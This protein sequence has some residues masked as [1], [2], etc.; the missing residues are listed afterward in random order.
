MHNTKKEL[1][2]FGEYIISVKAFIQNVGI[3][4]INLVILSIS[5]SIIFKP[6]AVDIIGNNRITLNDS[7]GYNSLKELLVFFN[8][9]IKK[10]P[11]AIKLTIPIKNVFKLYRLNA[12]SIIPIIIPNSSI[13]A[14]II[15]SNN[16]DSFI[17]G[18]FVF[19]CIIL[20]LK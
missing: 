20:L 1:N 4:K 19:N 11:I 10:I 12:A 3:G 9:L 5:D 7:N 16:S 18:Y 13:N 14:V 17:V 15:N 2:V 8:A 6:I